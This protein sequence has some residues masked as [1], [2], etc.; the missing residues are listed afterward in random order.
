[1]TKETTTQY[2][3]RR[4]GEMKGLHSKISRDTGIPQT[5]ISRIA[6]GKGSPRSDTADRLKAWIDEADKINSKIN[7]K[8]K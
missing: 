6:R 3:A 4:L 5:T 7:G 1:M 8:G 2:L